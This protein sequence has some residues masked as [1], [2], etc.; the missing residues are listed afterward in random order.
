TRSAPPGGRARNRLT[1]SRRSQLESTK[2]LRQPRTRTPSTD[3]AAERRARARPASPASKVHRSAALPPA[4]STRF[5][6]DVAR[7]PIDGN[8]R[9]TR[10]R[11]RRSTRPLATGT[12]GSSWRSYL[13]GE[14]S[15]TALEACRRSALEALRGGDA[16]LDRGMTVEEPLDDLRRLVL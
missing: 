15:Q 6:G 4:T 1:E 5:R 11:R 10:E 3:P 7:C 16:F 8:S 14:R 2:R 13:R 9:H 12:E